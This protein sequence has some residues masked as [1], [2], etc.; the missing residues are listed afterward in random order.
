MK[1]LT[2][3]ILLVLPMMV[4]A[5]WYTSYGVTDIGD[6]TP[7]QLDFALKKAKNIE[8]TGV[9]FTLLGVGSGIVGFV[10]QMKAITEIDYADP[11]ADLS[12]LNTGT[13]L[14]YGGVITASIGVPLW[15]AGSMRKTDIQIA[16][17]R[18]HLGYVP[19]VGIKITF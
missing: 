5:Q 12:K 14:L 9:V 2:F 19:S 18:Y 10:M 11:N 15:I 13:I 8:G 6:L 17:R 4:N 7:P 3:I 16:M 1:K